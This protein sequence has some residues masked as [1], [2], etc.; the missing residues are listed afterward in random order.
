[1]TTGPN[2][3]YYSHKYE[4]DTY[5]YRHVHITQDLVKDVP[6]NR[7]MTESEWRGI[8]IQQ[9]RGWKHYMVHSPERHVILFRRPKPV[10]NKQLNKKPS[11][12]SAV[13]YRTR[14]SEKNLL[15]AS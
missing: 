7:L 1:M 2:D 13:A 12:V 9:S 11:T 10:D 5:E 4:D 3:F 15:Q 8:G 14:S 6:K